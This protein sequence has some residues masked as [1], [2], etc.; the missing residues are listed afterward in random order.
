MPY[1][2]CDGKEERCLHSDGTSFFNFL[3]S[4]LESFTGAAW[5]QEDDITMVALQRK[6]L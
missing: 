5:E 4:E 1:G 6:S 3:L 2:R